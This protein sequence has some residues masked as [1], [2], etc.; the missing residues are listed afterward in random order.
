MYG[1]KLRIWMVPFVAT[2]YMYQSS[3]Y[4]KLAFW[5][6]G[7]VL[8]KLL[9]VAGRDLQRVQAG[10]AE[11]LPKGKFYP[12]YR[13]TNALFIALAVYLVLCFFVYV[14]YMGTL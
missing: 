9:A 3:L 11:P 13:I 10:K 4:A 6:G 14:R 12:Y 7:I 5:A 8:L 1:Y 2:W